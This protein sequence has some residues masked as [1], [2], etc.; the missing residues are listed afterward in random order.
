MDY[1]CARFGDFSFS[2]FGFISGQ[3][4]SQTGVTTVNS[5]EFS[6]MLCSKKDNMFIAEFWA[7][8]WWRS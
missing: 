3:T 7:V 1:P 6:P 8:N 2:H 5:D 4:E